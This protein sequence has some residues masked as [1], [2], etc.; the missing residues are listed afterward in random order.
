MVI[1]GG[2]GGVS[3]RSRP[4]WWQY[5]KF[6]VPNPMTDNIAS[7]ISLRTVPGMTQTILSSFGPSTAYQHIQ[8]YNG[9]WT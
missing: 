4:K 7:I 3:G 8:S 2:G 5:L 1:V 6:G 9:N